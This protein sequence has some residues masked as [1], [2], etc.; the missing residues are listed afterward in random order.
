MELAS[1]AATKLLP[2]LMRRIESKFSSLQV[3]MA[4]FRRVMKIVQGKSPIVR[5]GRKTGKT[6]TITG[7]Y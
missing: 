2:N 6:Q 1:A 5:I 7:G 3:D 4:D